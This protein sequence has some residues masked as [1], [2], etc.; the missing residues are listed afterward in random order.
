VAFLF[1]AAYNFD[2]LKTADISFAVRRRSSGLFR[3]SARDLNNKIRW[4]GLYWI[5]HWTILCGHVPVYLK[6]DKTTDIACSLLTLLFT[7]NV[8]REICTENSKCWQRSRA[9]P[10]THFVFVT[11]L[12][13]VLQFTRSRDS[14][15]GVAAQLQAGRY[16]IRISADARGAS[17]LQNFQ[18]DSETNPDSYSLGIVEFFSESKAAGAWCWPLTSI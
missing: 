4:S 10:R 12:P 17:F 15:V 3:P 11:L 16:K 13:C 7:C 18:S 9:E 8:R 1:S 6:S 14:S 2:V 5:W